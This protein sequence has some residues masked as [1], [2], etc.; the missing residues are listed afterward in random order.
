M[1]NNVS[2][3]VGCFGAM[4]RDIWN[5]GEDDEKKAAAEVGR[6]M[7]IMMMMRIA[8][9]VVVVEQRKQQNW[10][11]KFRIVLADCQQRR[12]NS[13]FGQNGSEIEER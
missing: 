6:L 1:T 13:L 11:M 8:V 2:P 5:F 10:L 9:L 12:K 4:R 3:L 7:M